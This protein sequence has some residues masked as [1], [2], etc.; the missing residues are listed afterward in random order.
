MLGIEGETVAV[1]CL[2]NVA[3]DE[4]VIP[5]DPQ[6][7]HAVPTGV[8][9]IGVPRWAE[10]GDHQIVAGRVNEEASRTSPG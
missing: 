8:D 3:C 1:G 9:S 4:P 10:T 7:V 2:G 5:P 6:G